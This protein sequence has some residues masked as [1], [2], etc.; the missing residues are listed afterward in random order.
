[1]K[2]RFPGLVAEQVV[3]GDLEALSGQAP[4]DLLE[5][6]RFSSVAK[7][8]V[9]SDHVRPRMFSISPTC[10]RIRVLARLGAPGKTDTLV[11]QDAT[12]HGYDAS[13]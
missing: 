9:T 12:G 10:R 8:D 4:W 13:T 2:K 7:V 5:E 3:L 11:G 1:M 6:T